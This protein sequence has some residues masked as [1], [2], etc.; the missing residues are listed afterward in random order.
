M[1]YHKYRYSIDKWMKQKKWDPLKYER[2]GHKYYDLLPS[3]YY[4][5]HTYGALNKS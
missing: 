1:R 4:T 3:L 2:K 5:N